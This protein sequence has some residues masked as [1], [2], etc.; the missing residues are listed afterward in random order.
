M[1]FHI[2]LPRAELCE[3]TKTRK[4]PQAALIPPYA[5]PPEN[6]ALGRRPGQVAS[7]GLEPLSVGLGVTTIQVWG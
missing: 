5:D 2:F 6:T 4:C 3:G 7:L 1:H